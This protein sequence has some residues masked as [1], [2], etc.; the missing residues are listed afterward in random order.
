MERTAGPQVDFTKS[1]YNDNELAWLQSPCFDFTNIQHPYVLF[2]FFLNTEKHY[3]GATLQYTTDNGISWITVGDIYD[4]MNCFNWNW[5]NA[6]AIKYLNN[7]VGW[8]GST[9][10]IWANH[11]ITSIAGKSNVRFRFL[12]GA[13]SINNHYNGFAV[14]DFYTGETDSTD[15]SFTYKC[16]SSNT[17]DFS[18]SS[19]KGC[20]DYSWDFG[21]PAAGPS[22]T[23]HMNAPSH[24]FSAP[25]TYTVTLS[26]IGPGNAPSITSQVIT[27]LKSSAK[28]ISQPTCAGDKN[29]VAIVRY[30]SCH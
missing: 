26:T 18:A 19:S 1:S 10:W 9:Y 8:S 17:I 29:G 2:R 11:T 23:S 5:Y 22:D 24:T 6:S 30:C 4:P 3:D 21:D 14:D 28:V 16:T 27:I 25:G 13:G 20:P 7:G 15:A 12:F